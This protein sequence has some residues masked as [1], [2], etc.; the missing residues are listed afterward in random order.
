[1]Q[2]VSNPTPFPDLKKGAEPQEARIV[3]H[4]DTGDPGDQADAHTAKAPAPHHLIDE[5]GEGVL[6]WV[7]DAQKSGCF[8]DQGEKGAQR[9]MLRAAR[10]T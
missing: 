6:P 5:G 1:M 2:P 3:L 8:L 10:S 9:P 4:P 7:L